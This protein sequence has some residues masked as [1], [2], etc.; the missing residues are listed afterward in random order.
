MTPRDGV[1]VGLSFR[2]EGV[3]VRYPGLVALDRVDLE[4]GAGERVALVGPS[5]AG[6][7]TLLRLLG[8]AI[9]PSSGRLWVAGQEISQLDE[10]ALRRLRSRLGTIHQDLRLVPN[11]RAL[12]NV[13]LGRLGRWSLP[14]SLRNILWP[15]RREVRAVLAILDR[16]GIGDKLY[17]RTDR[18]S[19]GERQRVAIARALYQHPGALLADEPVASLDPARADEVIALLVDLCRDGGITLCSSLHTLDTARRH[20]TRLVGLRQGRVVFDQ[21]T[22]SLEDSDFR[23]LYQLGET[24]RG[25]DCPSNRQPSGGEGA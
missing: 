23:R 12:H 21:D 22:A 2:L 11:L 6:K 5:G 16:V 18:L 7:T 3:S 15:P 24:D 25:L 8:G 19:G 20:L 17:Q 9:R 10:K 4:V 13:L 1:S 14:R